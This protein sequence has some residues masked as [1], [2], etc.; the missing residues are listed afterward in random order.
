M[1]HVEKL[2]EPMSRDDRIA[3]IGAR[4]EAGT[5]KREFIP[6][7]HGYLDVPVI[8][9]AA[10]TLVY[11]VDNGR[12]L[13]ELAIVAGEPAMPSETFAATAETP[14][15]Q[16]ILHGLLLDK[17][18]DPEGPVFEE[19]EAHAQQTEPLLIR[20]DGVVVNGNR[21]L[22]AMRELR[23]LDPQRYGAFQKVSVAVLPDTLSREEEEYIEA[24]LQMAPDLKLEYGWINRR[25][26]LRQH[27]QDLGI[28]RILSAYRFA[29]EGAVEA[30][31]A[32]L[33][34]AESYLDWIGS[35]RQFDLVKAAQERF[36][37]LQAQLSLLPDAYIRNVW[38]KIGFSMLRAADAI[39]ARIE[40]YFPFSEPVPP[41]LIQWVPRTMAEDRGFVDRQR[42][43]EN[44]AMNP[45]L[46]DRLVPTLTPQDAE[47]TARNAIA[48]IDT[49]K[50]DQ[51]RLLGAANVVNALRTARKTL[52]HL[53][54]A[55]LTADQLRIMRGELVSIEEYVRS[56]GDQDLPRAP[57]EKIFPR[58]Y[59]KLK[60]SLSRRD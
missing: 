22:A 56:L 2:P 43:G 48:L 39:D 17:A 50:S 55:D 13:S 52:E 5:D 51:Q 47:Q 46:V 33:E 12:V 38:R 1:K 8:D 34:L 18:K 36:H 10:D 6:S 40:H 35:P 60:R 21:R 11:R 24:A 49:L 42:R 29:D 37:G 54:A 27:R 9:I 41:A 16:A 7:E 28:E 44:R 15:T 3:A 23:H 19:F 30:E 4:L 45:A 58:V 57:R 32:E 53:G 59:H 25:L 26:K 20:A 14:E 31:L